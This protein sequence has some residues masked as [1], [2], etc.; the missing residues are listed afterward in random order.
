MSIEDTLRGLAILG[1]GGI[2][3][4]LA[5]F[6]VVVVAVAIERGLVLVRTHEDITRMRVDLARAL[7]QGDLLAA[8]T[9]VVASRSIE[10]RVVA[11]GL[12]ALPRGAASVEERMA[13]EAQMTRLAL[14]Q[15]LPVLRMVGSAAPLVGLLGTVLG[16]IH[17]F[18]AH[19]VGGSSTP[20]GALAGPLTATAAGLVVALAAIVLSNLIRSQIS[21]RM[22][23]AEALGR[24]M[25][26]YV[27]DERRSLAKEAAVIPGGLAGWGNDTTGEKASTP[28]R[29]LVLTGDD[30]PDRATQGAT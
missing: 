21:C 28:P 11:A 7:G 16:F 17:A 4:L 23:R 24:E 30:G 12:G 29:W 10:A 14:E 25:L 27:K 5:A 22:A 20:S 1:A 19:D 26:S 18:E 3:W 15:R 6:V 2:M 9:C 13:S 8:R